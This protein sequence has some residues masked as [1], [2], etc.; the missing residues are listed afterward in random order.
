MP[1][2][3]T[4]R[5]GFTG[6]TLIELLVTISIVGLLVSLSV[7]S[8]KAAREQAKRV[9]CQ[10]NMKQVNTALLTYVTELDSYPV[11]LQVSARNCRPSWATW[12]F[13]GWTGRDFET[14]CDAQGNGVHCFQTYQRP[15]SV[16]MSEPYPILPDQKGPDGVFGG[17]D[18][19]QTEMPVFKCPADTVSTQWRWRNS[20]NASQNVRDMSAY[21]QCGTSYQM[22]FYWFYQAL[23]R[24]E[25]PEGPCNTYRRWNQAFE[26]GRGLW[27]RAA[28]FGGA[29]RFITLVEDPFDWGV[30]QNLTRAAN[31]RADENFRHYV[32]GEQAMG[33]H[34]TWSRHMLAFLD[35]HVDYQY[36]DT[37]YQREADWTVTDD[38]WFDTRHRG[39]C[40]PFREP[41]CPDR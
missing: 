35:G 15:L 2:R 25:V 3:I 33:F 29:P 5:V 34:G 10:S 20:E 24:S 4:Q 32:T 13:G 22:N 14:Y 30:A 27:G 41:S 1:R 19:V 26:I 21:E 23:A 17:L 6:F 9:V 16:Y 31:A 38:R 7:P 39:N 8:I 28:E 11:L 18:D 37:R 40:P 12:S 36:A